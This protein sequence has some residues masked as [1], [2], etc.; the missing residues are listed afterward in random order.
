MNHHLEGSDKGGISVII[1]VKEDFLTVATAF[2]ETGA[3]AL[4]FGKKETVALTLATEEIFSYLCKASPP[5]RAIEIRCVSKGYYLR[6]TFLFGAEDFNIRAFN[7]TASVSFDDESSLDEMGLMIASRFV[8]RLRFRQEKSGQYELVLVKEKTYPEPDQSPLPR[9]GP[10]K[11]FKIHEP[12]IEELKLFSRLLNPLYKD[13]I[14]PE[15]FRFPGKLADMITSGEY[16]ALLAFGPTGR[17]GGGIM[18]H[19][20]GRK[21]V[22][23]AGPYLFLEGPDPRLSESLIEA[24]LGAIA[25]TPAIGLINRFPTEDLPKAYFEPL[26]TLTVYS[27]EGAETILPAYFRQMHEDLGSAVWSH[28]LLEDFLRQQYGRFVFPREIRKV[29]S[30]GEEVNPYS[31]LTADIDKSQKLITL[32]PVRSGRDIE[33]NLNNHLRL[34]E[35]EAYANIFFEMDLGIPWHAHFTPALF[36][37]GFRPRL[38]LPYAGEGDMVVFQLGAEAA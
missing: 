13:Q 6:L 35:K 1:P 20:S 5:D 32:R 27:G 29:E 2:V 10:I 17:I 26:G 38:L 4:G 31:V 15:A 30:Q 12:D 22:D 23:C 3:A 24:C 11:D 19:W 9:T 37:E 18:W 36:G 21:T 7:M 8:D 16:R 14:I 28:P 33:T 34:F 25:K